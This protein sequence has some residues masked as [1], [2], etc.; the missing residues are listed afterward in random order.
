MI[1]LKEHLAREHVCQCQLL[2]GAARN[3]LGHSINLRLN[4]RVELNH[5]VFANH[6]IIQMVYRLNLPEGGTEFERRRAWLRTEMLS[7][8]MVSLGIEH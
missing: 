1:L 7:F 6:G 8:L 4:N 5:F 3:N 2:G